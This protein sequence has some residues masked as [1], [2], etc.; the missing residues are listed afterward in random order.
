[1]IRIISRLVVYLI[2]SIIFIFPVYF[3]FASVDKIVF[4]NDPQTIPV[5]QSSGQYQIQLQNSSGG[6]EKAP[7]TTYFTLPLDLGSF[8][9]TKDGIPFTASTKVYI[10]TGNSNKYFYF[11][12]NISGTFTMR[13]I[14]VNKDGT[15]TW[16][17]EQV[18][19]VGSSS[20]GDGTTSSSTATTTSSGDDDQDNNTGS[21][22]GNISTH[23]EEENLSNYNDTSNVFQVSA[24]R[25]RLSYVGSNVKF[26]AKYEASGDCAVSGKTFV[27]SFGDGTSGQSEVISH[28]YKYPGEYNIILNGNC[29]GV[30][31]VSRTKVSIIAPNLEM[32]L[33]DNGLIEIKNNNGHEMNLG[34]WRIQSGNQQYLFPK[35]TIISANRGIAL[36]KE[37]SNILFGNQEITLYDPSGKIIKKIMP[38]IIKK[39]EKISTNQTKNLGLDI[40]S[41]EE[42]KKFAAEYNRYLAMFNKN[43][44]TVVPSIKEGVV[45]NNTNYQEEKVTTSSTNTISVATVVEAPNL[46]SGFW[47]RIVSAPFNGIK[48]IIST[49]YDF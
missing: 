19:V 40:S 17:T 46:S 28:A 1:M 4:I 31:S 32:S 23:S 34:E 36:A 33:G 35:D 41:K 16:Q 37:Y 48:A 7:D 18:V 42:V 47:R 8:S 3:A 21:G 9:S 44:K 25:E 13:I 11:K 12:S 15:K 26:E 24:G 49:F 27:W 30:D 22:D 20:S 45:V 6:I 39:E 5:G 43:P 14:A 29:N 38:E 10:A 2:S